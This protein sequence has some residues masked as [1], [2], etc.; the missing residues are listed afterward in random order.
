MPGVTTRAPRGKAPRGKTELPPRWR[1]SAGDY[2]VAMSVTPDGSLCAIATGAGAVLGVDMETGAV[3]WRSEAHR[4]GALALQFSPSGALLAT[5]GQDGNARLF[6]LAGA[7]VAELPGGAAWVEHVAWAPD[8]ELLATASGRTVRIW[9]KRGEPVVE[10]EPLPSTIAA[11]AWR[12]DRAELAAACYGGVYLWSVGA[13]ATSRHLA[14]QGSLVSMAW[15]PDGKVIACGSQDR[16]VH[17]WRLATGQDS[18]MRGYPAKPKALAWDAQSRLLATGGAPAVTLW[19][20]SGKGPEGTRPIELEGHMDTCV[21]LA[22]SPRKGV[23]ASGARDHGVLL[24]EP[25]RLARP[26]RYAFLEAEVTA[27]VWHPAHAGL[28]GADASGTVV[29]WQVVE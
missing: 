12:A 9:T 13:G 7:L 28:L 8:G 18:E 29:C 23:L 21:Q 17:F 6:D 27:L 10:T 5:C 11:L 3:R 24:W 20:F 19:D 1:L 16:S 2:V 14:W 25:R 4:S 22:F 26:V 15:S